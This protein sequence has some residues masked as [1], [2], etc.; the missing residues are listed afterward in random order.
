MVDDKDDE[1]E[2]TLKP[3]KKRMSTTGKIGL[4]ALVLAGA[5]IVAWPFLPGSGITTTTVETS[6]PEEFQDGDGSGF[7]AITVKDAPAAPTRERP[8]FDPG[9]KPLHHERKVNF[10][11]FSPSGFLDFITSQKKKLRVFPPVWQGLKR[12]FTL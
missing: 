2:Y 12:C 6:Q 9:F 8:V 5:T 4:T 7:G 10:F 1:Q 11:N 3:P